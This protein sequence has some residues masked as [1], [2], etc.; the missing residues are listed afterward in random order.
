MSFLAVGIDHQ[1]APLE[2][3]ERA[4]VPEDEWGKVLW[5]SAG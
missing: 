2:L 4:T 5:H 1:N 3:L